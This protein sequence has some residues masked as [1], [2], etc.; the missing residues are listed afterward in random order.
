MAERY[1]RIKTMEEMRFQEDSPIFL[2]KAA[3]L[4]D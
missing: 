2:E 4:L 3:L 1:R